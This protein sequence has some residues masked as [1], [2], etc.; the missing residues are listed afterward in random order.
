MKR[1]VKHV[2]LL[3]YLRGLAIL[4]VL[5]FHTLGT[6]FGYDALP[7]KGAWRD[8]SGQASFLCF[9]PLG[10]IGQAGV[11][12]FFVVSGFCIHT[13]FQQAG[14]D[15]RSFFVRRFFRIYP[16]YLLA[17]IYSLLILAA[18]SSVNFCDREFWLQLST[19]LFLVHNF[20]RATLFGINASF[21]SLAIEAQLYLV[22]PV[23]LALVGRIGW[24][25]AMVILAGCELLIRGVDGVL[26][27]AGAT[28][29]IAGDVSWLLASS[30]LG[31]WFSW[32]LGAALADA[33]L[34][35]RPL[36][37]LNLS[38]GGCLGL[39]FACY[40]ARPLCGFQFLLFALATAAIAGRGLSGVWPKLKM[41]LFFGSLLQR[42][43]WWS[44]S[45]YLLHQPLLQV[46]SHLVVW[47][48]AAQ[49]RP[50]PVAFLL[51]MAAW[52]VVIPLSILWYKTIEIPGI[53]LGRRLVEKP[54]VHKGAVIEPKKFREDDPT[55]L[56]ARA[57]PVPCDRNGRGLGFGYGLMVTALVLGVTGSLLVSARFSLQAAVEH[58]NLAWALA[59]SPEAVKRDGALAVELAEEAC[60]ETQYQM[61][62]LVGTLA[63]AYAEAG[64][65]DDAIITAQKACDLAAKNGET[66]LLRKNQELL[67]LYQNH[68]PY[69][70]RQAN[71]RK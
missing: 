49:Y 69:R 65:F 67:G 23:L 46:C 47:A 24:R 10:M 53:A 41:P 13:S 61:T 28:N 38:P 71:S 1:S 68:Q 66:D 35:E 4:A 3:D 26:Q 34:N 31:Y 9:L 42:I 11:A 5:I 48:V 59:T 44:Y 21:W 25:P 63:A 37:F 19:H 33:F 6:T 2:E 62:T 56:L 8:F 58:N 40:F 50:A 64:R 18:N 39:A 70:D 45:I 57:R 55:G 14:Q 17:L 15:W 52:L 16:P 29:T 7:W 60:Q 22:Y 27:T 12:I 32:A 51:T 30:P 43:G 20:H 36:P 54:A